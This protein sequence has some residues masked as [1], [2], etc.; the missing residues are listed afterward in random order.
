MCVAGFTGIIGTVVLLFNLQREESIEKLVNSPTIWVGRAIQGISVG[1]YGVLCP[2][3]INELVPIELSVNMG[4]IH[5]LM[6]SLGALF[7]KI[8]S[9]YHVPPWL[10]F[11]FPIPIL[12]I[13][14]IIMKTSF[15]Y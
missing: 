10:L 4:V 15:K 1:I 5:Q 2:I 14:I 11:S 6:M 8:F 13:Q 7:V 12:L 9:K 3:F